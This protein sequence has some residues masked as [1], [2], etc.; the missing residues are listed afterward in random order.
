MPYHTTD[1]R[2]KAVQRTPVG[3][4]VLVARGVK[5]LFQVSVLPVYLFQAS[6]LSMT[7]H[8]F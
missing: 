1:R 6:G 7:I 3:S 2:D 4:L 5:F 8:M